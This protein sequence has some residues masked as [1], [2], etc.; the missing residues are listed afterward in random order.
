MQHI[1]HYA[2]TLPIGQH[3]FYHKNVEI[4]YII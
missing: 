3:T 2:T 4:S 1:G